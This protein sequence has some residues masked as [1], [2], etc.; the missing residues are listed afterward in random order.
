MPA[1]GVG[2]N[3]WNASGPEQARLRDTLAAALDVG[4][5]F[6]DTA[7]V[8][9]AGRSELALG[10]AT[11]ADGRPVLMASKF[12][13]FPI[14]LPRPSSR[15]RW[16]RRWSGSAAIRLT[17]TTCTSPTPRSVLAPG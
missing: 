8:Y 1:L 6:F 7:E 12:A 10:E 17:C 16:T 14:G 3:R 11:R 4:M 13:P 15:P 2:T 9:N 5:G